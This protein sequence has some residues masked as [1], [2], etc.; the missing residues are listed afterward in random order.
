M[1]NKTTTAK[2]EQKTHKEIVKLKAKLEAEMGQHLTISD[3]IYAAVK[4][5]NDDFDKRK[6]QLKLEL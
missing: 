6:K 2:I 5:A 1:I 4:A 3:V